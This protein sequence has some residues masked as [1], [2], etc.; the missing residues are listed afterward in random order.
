M[1]TTTQIMKS[2]KLFL[3]LL[4]IAGYS[5]SQAQGD[6]FSKFRPAQ[7]WSIGAQFSPTFGHSDAPNEN[8]SFSGGLH[9]KYSV[10]QTVG[11]KASTN[12]GSMV[13]NRNGTTNFWSSTRSE[14]GDSYEY[15]NKFMDA[16]VSAVITAGNWSFLRPLRKLQTYVSA[17]VGIIK[18]DVE[19]SFADG[20]DA[21]S[22]FRSFPNSFV[23]YDANNIETTEPAAV[24]QAK[25]SYANTDLTYPL[26]L[27]LKY[28]L[29]KNFDLGLEW[30]TRLTRS[31]KLDAFSFDVKNNRAWDY[32][33]TLGVQLA[34]K[35]GNKD[36]DDHY[37]WLNPVETLFTDID[38]INKGIKKLMADTDG[39]GVGD[40]FDKDNETPKGV[41][42]YGDGTAVDTDGDG[43]PDSQ[44]QEKFSLVTDVDENGIAKDDDNDGIPNS[45]DEEPNSASGSIVDAKGKTIE[46]NNSS[47]NCRNVTLP[48]IMFD[49]GSSQ[50]S[51]SSY[52]VLYTLA[53][54]LRMCPSLNITATGYT[55]SK[56]GER[57]AWKRANAIID[58]LEA[59]YGIERSRISI[60]YAAGSGIEFA[61]KRIDFTQKK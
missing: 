25:S 50:I 53:E 7:K 60:D 42:T 36:R 59:N 3:L 12:L 57:L 40:Y 9:L 19:G 10:S 37:D 20:A 24:V 39:D 17:G 47:Y 13:G 61:S 28:N 41:K 31:D 29:S 2:F 22:Y 21:N 27:G 23:G 6:Y 30:K 18:S 8:L 32:Y 1:N 44:D 49:G 52:G 4:A 26:G 51:S 54:K 35:F 43:V 56:S 46:I 5:S 11:F 33:S 55:Q 16:D 45:L 38:S 48:T 34:F 14:S 58:H 15:T